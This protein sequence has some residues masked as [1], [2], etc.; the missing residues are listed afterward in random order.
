MARESRQMLMPPLTV[1]AFALQGA[2]HRQMLRAQ[3]L[4]GVVRPGFS[5]EDDT[6]GTQRCGAWKLF[7][8]LHDLGCTLGLSLVLSLVISLVLDVRRHVRLLSA[9]RSQRM[10]V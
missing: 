9:R 7:K 3:L 8:P 4:V 2:K 1:P 5:V 6:E 10:I